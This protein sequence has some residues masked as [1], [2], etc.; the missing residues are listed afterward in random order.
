VTPTFVA[1]PPLVEVAPAIAPDPPR[2]VRP[3]EPSFVPKPPPPA[4]APKSGPTRD[5]PMTP[6]FPHSKYDPAIDVESFAGIL[7]EKYPEP[8]RLAGK[9]TSYLKFVSPE[10]DYVGGGKNRAYDLS[11]RAT[12]PWPNGDGGVTAMAGPWGIVFAAPL[13]AEAL[14]VGK[15]FEAMRSPFREGSKPGLSFSGD[16][17]GNNKLTGSFAVWQLDIVNGEVIAL[18]ADFLQRSEGKG[19][20]LLGRLRYK[21]K[22]E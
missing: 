11:A 20:P 19:P 3:V 9:I 7:S 14:P 17:R 15:Y 8:R 2:V 22:Y 12:P 6:D 5:N 1:R 4:E 18:A 21:S 16:G 13:G 10:G